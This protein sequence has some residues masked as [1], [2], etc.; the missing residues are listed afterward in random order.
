MYSLHKP[1]SALRRAGVIDTATAATLQY[2]HFTWDFHDIRGGNPTWNCTMGHV[3]YAY[4]MY[5]GNDGDYTQQQ[6]S[7]FYSRTYGLNK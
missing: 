2:A 5:T 3:S 4:D 7:R 1:L 6:N